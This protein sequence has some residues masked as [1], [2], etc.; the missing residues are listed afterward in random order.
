[1][2]ETARVKIRHYVGGEQAEVFAGFTEDLFVALA[3]RFPPNRI[4]RYDGNR[5]GDTVSL[6]LGVKPLAQVWT[7]EI[8]ANEAGA[9][10]SFFVDEGR[11][12]PFPLTFWRHR[13]VV[14]QAGP[15]RVAIVED[16]V[17]ATSNAVF[18]KLMRPIIVR[19]F[20]ARGPGYQRYFGRV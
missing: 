15:G 6:E 16:I 12:L 9:E 5:V 7:T 13:H 17:F 18:T 4:L 14:E 1:M 2:S 11:E 3:P 19:E 10:R 20:G 8:V